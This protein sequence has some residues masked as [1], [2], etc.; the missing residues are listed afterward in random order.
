[1]AR[2]Q[3]EA[4]DKVARLDVE[5][6]FN[7]A[8]C[9]EEVRLAFTETGED[10]RLLVP[11]H[12]RTESVAG[13]RAVTGDAVDFEPG[14]VRLELGEL[15]DDLSDDERIK[16]AVL[17]AH[18]CQRDEEKRESSLLGLTTK[19]MPQKSSAPGLHALRRSRSF[20]SFGERRS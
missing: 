1:M 19:M 15:F 17:R 10:G 9:D 12:A 14:E 20:C 6:F 13:A 18:D 2:V 8:R 7:D 3:V 5:A 16:A 11:G 4:S